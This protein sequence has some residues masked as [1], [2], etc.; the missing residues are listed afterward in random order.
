MFLSDRTMAYEAMVSALL[1]KGPRPEEGA[2]EAL[3][4][5]ERARSRSL[6][7]LLAESQ[8]RLTDPRLDAVRTEERRFSSRLSDLQRRLLAATEP[9]VRDGL[10]TEL[11]AI[12]RR[13]ESCVQRR[14]GPAGIALN[15]EFHRMLSSGCGNQR[16][17]DLLDEL[18]SQV[19]RL[20]YWSAE[21]E[22]Q[23][24]EAVRQHDEIVDALERGEFDAA[25][26]LLR[27][28][29]LQTYFAFVSEMGSA[30]VAT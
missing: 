16:L 26:R 20:E 23:A 11:R 1:A 4:V 21:H 22:P 9:T 6:A 17:C 7:D 2:R 5:A 12:N 29:R 15:H 30:G 25:L 24:E 19:L 14:D 27:Q 8:Q 10:L 13:M 28:N 18:R 3:S